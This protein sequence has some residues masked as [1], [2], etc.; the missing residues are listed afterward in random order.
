WEAAVRLRP[1]DAVLHQ[2][3]GQAS[4]DL[5]RSEPN[6]ER[7]AAAVRHLV[8][9]RD[10]CPVLAHPHARLGELA[11]AL[12]RADSPVR[13]FERAAR[14][15]PSESESW[16]GL[17]GAYLDVGRP[18]EAQAAWRR[19]LESGERLRRQLLDRAVAAWGVEAVRQSV[20]PDRPDVWIAAAQHL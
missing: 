19:Y 6:P 12:S 2:S 3:A 1:G 10:L 5:H 7:V 17:G 16:Y 4:L 14:R 15:L 20:L 18:A 13:Y 9:A 8:T 11:A